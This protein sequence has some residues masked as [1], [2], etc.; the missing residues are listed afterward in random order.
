MTGVLPDLVRSLS[1]PAQLQSHQSILLSVLL[2]PDFIAECA[3]DTGHDPAVVTQLIKTYINEIPIGVTVLEG[4]ELKGQKILEVGAGLGLLGLLL[5]F[6]GHDITL[7]EPGAG[8]FG[9]N[10]IVG[11]LLRK[12]LNITNL[13]ILDSG[14]ETLMPAQHGSFDVI[15]SVNV[16]EH[17]DDLDGAF[18][19]MVSV[20]APEGVM[21][22]NSPNYFVP[23]DPHFRLLLIPF[24]PQQTFWFKPSLSK[25]AVWRSLNFITARRVLQLCKK[26]GLICTFRKGLLADAFQRLADDPI[27]RAR[28]PAYLRLILAILNFTGGLGL[29]R[30]FPAVLATPM[31]FEA[32]RPIR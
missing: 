17:L 19:G 9:F 12:R 22:H 7:L 15:F 23:Y 24:A 3:K 1:L 6:S 11:R 26:Q 4:I 30:Y 5:H 28:Q 32:R 21:V 16:L 10:A 29:L 13:P 27:F 8:G 18:R 20:L 31:T 2:Q 14:C 25:D